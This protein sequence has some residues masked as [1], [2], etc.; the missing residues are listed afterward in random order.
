M[1]CPKSVVPVNRKNCTMN[2]PKNWKWIF[3]DKTILV[4]FDNPVT[5][6][7]NLGNATIL[8][9]AVCNFDVHD[10]NKIIPS[11]SKGFLTGNG[12]LYID[13]ESNIYCA[14]QIGKGADGSYIM[15]S[16]DGD[17]TSMLIPN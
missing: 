2:V 8:S 1:S 3:P 5:N 4:T 9:R 11:C 10:N 17:T 12:N 15:R 13:A 7:Y 6:E 16:Q 14:Y